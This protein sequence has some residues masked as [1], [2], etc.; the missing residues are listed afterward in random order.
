[1]RLC[2][3]G[4]L[5][6]MSDNESAARRVGQLIKRARKSA[7]F[8]QA[9]VANLLEEFTGETYHPSTVSKI[10]AGTRPLGLEESA[11]IA[12]ALGITP[13]QLFRQIAEEPTGEERIARVEQSSGNLAKYLRETLAMDAKRLGLEVAALWEDRS[14]G[15][16]DS[17][18]LV[19]AALSDVEPILQA[20]TQLVEL[21]FEAAD[22]SQLVSSLTDLEAVALIM[23][24]SQRGK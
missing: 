19:V 12:R 13:D 15:K 9:D 22:K 6:P 18:P 1:M 5:A 3:C 2:C 11:H 23:R 20:T 14:A 24:D 17:E 10:E 7:N 8:T 4:I 16:L 21:L